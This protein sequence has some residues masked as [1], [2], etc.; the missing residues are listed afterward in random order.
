MAWGD[1]P[2]GVTPWGGELDEEEVVDVTP[3]PSGSAEIAAAQE[4]ALGTDIWLDL[5]GTAGGDRAIT[6]AGDWLL[7]RGREAYRQSLIRR[8]V[9]ADGDWKTKPGYGAGGRL[10]VKGG[11]SRA[12]LDRF[13]TRL[14]E[15]ALKDRR[16][17][18]VKDVIV[19]RGS[20]GTVKFRVVAIPKGELLGN[21]PVVISGEMGAI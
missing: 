2:W 15:Q 10:M 4:A 20:A 17:D 7:A 5:A 16:T 12:E 21:A 11:S 18:S 3:P 8:F 14:R 1:G 9:S 19:A 13:S 6:S